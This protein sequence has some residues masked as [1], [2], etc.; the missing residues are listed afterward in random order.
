MRAQEVTNARL[1]LP[2]LDRVNGSSNVVTHVKGHV[3]GIPNFNC[4]CWRK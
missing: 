4:F 1:E 3:H 2:K